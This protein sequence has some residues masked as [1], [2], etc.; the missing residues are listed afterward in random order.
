MQAHFPEGEFF[1]YVL[2]GIGLA[3]LANATLYPGVDQSTREVFLAGARRTLEAIDDPFVSDRFGSIESLEHGIFYRGWRLELVN[4]IVRAGGDDLV[5]EQRGEAMAILRAVQASPAGWVEGY[6]YSYWPCDTVVGLAAAADA[7]PDEAAPVV[8]AWLDVIQ[9]DAATRLLPHQVTADGAT[10]RAPQGSSQTIIQA[11]QK[12]PS[13]LGPV[14]HKSNP[15][16]VQLNNQ[17]TL[18][19][20]NLGNS[21]RRGACYG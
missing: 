7:L 13:V 9:V 2:S 4:A 5:G 18:L 17:L 6:P 3:R 11:R 21:L 20:G 19:S 15:C 8:E 1:T 10:V 16:V 14:L 12:S